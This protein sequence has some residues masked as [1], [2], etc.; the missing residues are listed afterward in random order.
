[1]K[2][3]V[4]GQRLRYNGDST[5]STSDEYR[6]IGVGKGAGDDLRG[7]EFAVY[8]TPDGEIFVRSPETFEE[9]MEKFTPPPETGYPVIY[10]K[11]LVNRLNLAS[12]RIYQGDVLRVDESTI[13]PVYGLAEDYFQ[14]MVV[15]H[16]RIELRPA[17]RGW[18]DHLVTVQGVVGVTMP[19]ISNMNKLGSS[20]TPIDLMPKEFHSHGSQQQRSVVLSLLES[21]YLL[22]EGRLEMTYWRMEGKNFVIYFAGKMTTEHLLFPE[23]PIAIVAW[24]S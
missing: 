5:R 21:I 10:Q 14:D 22:F 2:D 8:E 13:G 6:M 15:N 16:G 1:M 24:G 11:D 20:T 4:R 23:L 19:E 12:R 18:L 17:G 7:K 9:K 3:I